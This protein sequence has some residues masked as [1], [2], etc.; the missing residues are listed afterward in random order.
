MT[1]DPEVTADPTVPS[2]PPRDIPMRL[3]ERLSLD[4]LAELA[5][6]APSYMAATLAPEAVTVLRDALNELDRY[7]AGLVTPS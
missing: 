1:D 4:L 7:R 6:N 3:T 5:R 2:L